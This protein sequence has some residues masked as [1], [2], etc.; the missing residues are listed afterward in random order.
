[1]EHLLLDEVEQLHT[2]NAEWQALNVAWA[3]AH[4]ELADGWK[5]EH[6]RKHDHGGGNWCDL[7]NND[8]CVDIAHAEPPPDLRDGDVFL[9]VLTE[10]MAHILF[11]DDLRQWGAAIP[12]TVTN[13]NWLYGDDPAEALA[14][15]L[16]CN[17]GA[18]MKK[19][20]KAQCKVCKEIIESK[21]RHDFQVCKCWRERGD[22]VGGI[23]VDGGL[24]YLRRVGN[25]DNFIELSEGWDDD[26]NV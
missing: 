23:A 7:C 1:M 12:R 8:N 24:D 26:R 11:D 16:I 3:T 20:N 18:Y 21:H 6:R 13:W 10:S 4:P 2:E 22:G 5:P 19:T 25:L 17:E 9:R 15:A 14:R